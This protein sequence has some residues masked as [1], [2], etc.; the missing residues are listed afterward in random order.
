[1]PITSRKAR[2][3]QL[4]GVTRSSGDGMQYKPAELILSIL[5]YGHGQYTVDEVI[6]LV[7]LIASYEGEKPNAKQTELKI[8][9]IS[10]LVDD[11]E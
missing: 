3:R 1:M 6:E 7:E 9:P 10:A 4:G 8:V 2:C 5:Y 11:Y